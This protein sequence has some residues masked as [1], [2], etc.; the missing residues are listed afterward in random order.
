M[1]TRYLCP[2]FLAIAFWLPSAQGAVVPNVAGQSQA[3]ATA[4]LTNAGL[5]VGTVTERA[6]PGVPAC[7]VIS[8]TPAA[9]SS[10]AAGTA[11]NLVISPCP[12][13][14]RSA[15]PGSV[16]VS[17]RNEYALDL[18]FGFLGKG[19]RNGTDEAEGVLEKRG[20]RYVGI[21]T[22]KVDSHQ[23]L[24]GMTGN[25]GPGH[26]QDSQELDVVG[27]PVAG[28]NARSQTV[29]FNTGNAG[30][31]YLALKFTPRTQTAQQP[32]GRNDN[33]ELVVAC[34]T[35][36]EPPSGPPFLPLNDARWT[37]PDGG[38][39][40]ALPASGVL[41]YTDNTVAGASGTAAAPIFNVSKSL[42][43]IRVERL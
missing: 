28:F 14:S 6:S 33:G 13:P 38:Y 22:A 9:G 36:I 20:D 31:E 39:I 1:T 35:L 32:A 24:S 3:A 26:Y 7:T 16:R 42:W 41:N 2:V 18:N 34:H 25:C 19:N 4:S 43:T 12:A 23:T 27:H 5:V 21:M 29:T 11:V 40:I 10:V 17:I 30:S 15:A 37:M 8:Q